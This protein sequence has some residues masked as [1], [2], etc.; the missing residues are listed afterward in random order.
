MCL[1]N[2][3]LKLDQHSL[4]VRICIHFYDTRLN[5]ICKKEITRIYD[6]EVSAQEGAVSKQSPSR[7][8]VKN[9]DT[10]QVC[11]AM[12]DGGLGDCQ[13]VDFGMFTPEKGF[14][15]GDGNWITFVEPGQGVFTCGI[16]EEHGTVEKDGCIM[17]LELPYEGTVNSL[18]VN[19]QAEKA[20]VGLEDDSWLVCSI[21]V[22]GVY[23][24]CT[25][26]T[27]LGKVYDIIVSPDGYNLY[28]ITPDLTQ[29]M[30]C[31]GSLTETCT[32]VSGLDDSGAF[33]HVLLSFESADTVF[34]EEMDLTGQGRY[35]IAKC[36]VTEPTVFA[37]CTQIKE[38]TRG[39]YLDLVFAN[40]GE[41]VYVATS[42]DTLNDEEEE[43]FFN[44]FT[45]LASLLTFR[46]PG[47]NVYITQHVD[48]C[49]AG[50]CN[51]TLE[52]V[53]EFTMANITYDYS[54]QRSFLNLM[55]D[56]ER[57]YEWHVCKVDSTFL[58]G[59]VTEDCKLVDIQ[60]SALAVTKPITF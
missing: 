10:A 44:P 48:I 38:T 15:G 16:D 11:K 3:S 59:N 54:K 35:I 5:T 8:Y 58:F 31:D 9:G 26:G 21:T 20:W 1:V 55:E 27:V 39:Q 40:D 6:A 4:L 22:E 50:Y 17:S 14:I 12:S 49:H 33:G 43:R 52:D 42:T 24:D 53:M 36:D 28:I 30:Y 45:F 18:I 13:N 25:Q 34:V 60:D 46:K 29:I 37:S 56:E 47:P 7:W 57:G 32:P 19:N 51:I 2:V 41:S 23:T